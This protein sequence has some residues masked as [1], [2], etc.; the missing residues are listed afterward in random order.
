MQSLGK[1]NR[2][3]PFLDDERNLCEHSS[4]QP[5]SKRFVLPCGRAR[6]KGSTIDPINRDLCA[7][8][9]PLRQKGDLLRNPRIRQCGAADAEVSCCW[10]TQPTLHLSLSSF[11]HEVAFPLQKLAKC[12]LC[13]KEADRSGNIHMTSAGGGE[14][15]SPKRRR[16]KG[17]CV[18]SILYVS[19]QCGCHMR[20]VPG[21]FIATLSRV[22]G[23][24][25]RKNFKPV[26][27]HERAVLGSTERN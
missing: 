24:P 10:L 20:K 7:L 6:G 26:H 18:N 13:L 1:R 15:R 22:G 17:G 12:C 4:Q 19:T 25:K 14:G 23:C 2:R 11:S 8:P 9:S 5:L 16:E 21:I 3:G 27:V